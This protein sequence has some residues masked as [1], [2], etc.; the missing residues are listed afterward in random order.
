MGAR[1]GARGLADKVID[2]AEKHQIKTV[3]LVKTVEEARDA[4]PTGTALVFVV[5][6][7]FPIKEIV[8]VA[9]KSGSW[10]HAMAWTAC[11]D[12]GKEPAFLCKIVGV[13]GMV[14]IPNGVRYQMVHF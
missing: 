7:D 1:W 8:R 6:M 5:V 12:A 2:E 13:N 14:V 4:Q 9:R 11:D 10:A 3:S